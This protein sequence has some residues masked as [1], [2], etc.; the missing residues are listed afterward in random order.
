MRY[1]RVSDR[2]GPVAP[3]R[4][5]EPFRSD[6]E[7]DREWVRMLFDPPRPETKSKLSPAVMAYFHA[8]SPLYD[9]DGKLRD[10]QA[11]EVGARIDVDA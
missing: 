7:T 3:V 11:L 4:R 8:T 6:D 9:G 2:F 1:L 5:I 10:R